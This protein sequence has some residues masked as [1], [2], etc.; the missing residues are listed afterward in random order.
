MNDYDNYSSKFNYQCSSFNYSDIL[1]TFLN[2]LQ[3]FPF[4]LRGFF[5]KRTLNIFVVCLIYEKLQME[6]RDVMLCTLYVLNRV[7]RDVLR[8]IW[9]S[10]HDGGAQSIVLDYIRLLEV[11]LE[12]FKYRGKKEVLMRTSNKSVFITFNS[13]FC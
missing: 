13:N 2:Q 7:P 4:I 11:A 6:C 9:S 10:Q 8:A 1:R 3:F 5:L 12:L